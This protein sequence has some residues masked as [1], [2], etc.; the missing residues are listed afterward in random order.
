MESPWRSSRRQR[1]EALFDELGDERE[2]L[3]QAEEVECTLMERVAHYEDAGRVVPDRLL[4]RLEKVRER[5]GWIERMV[6][7]VDE[8]GGWRLQV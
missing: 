7:E 2:L 5:I 4:E 1:E 3:R 8:D 6:A